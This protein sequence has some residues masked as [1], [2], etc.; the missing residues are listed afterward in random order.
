MHVFLN[1]ITAKSHQLDTKLDKLSTDSLSLSLH[2]TPLSLISPVSIT[3]SPLS[4]VHTIPVKDASSSP[5]KK[6]SS[7]SKTSLTTPEK[8]IESQISSDEEEVLPL[9]ERLKMSSPLKPHVKESDVKCKR[10][11]W[12]SK[13]C[14]IELSD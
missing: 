7:P 3:P 6:R 2:T 5:L 10:R 1:R 8:R 4:S 9:M 13:E 11:I 12:G 14:P